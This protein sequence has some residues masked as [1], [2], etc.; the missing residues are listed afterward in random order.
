MSEPTI[1]PFGMWP[2]PVT[3]EMVTGGTV[4][5][6]E[7][8][9][10]G[11]DLYWTELRP[12]ERGRRA[13]VRR[14][15]AGAI[16]DVLPG[17]A[18]LGTRVHE[19]GG[20]AYAVSGGTI[21]YA[22]RSDD[23]VRLVMPGAEPRVLV[24]VAGCRYAAFA[25]DAEH[26]R[27][28]AVREDHRDRPSTAPLNAL[29]VLPLAGAVDA[30]NDAG[31]V[32]AEGHDFFLEP[33]VAP[34]GSRLAW[35]AYDHPDMPWNATRLYVA[36]IAANGTLANVRC[37]AGEAGGESI[38]EVRWNVDGTLLFTSD[39]TNYWNPYV[40]DGDVVTA[41]APAAVEFGE[42]H[43]VFGRGML[44]PLD[45]Q[46]TLCAFIRDGIERPG[47]IAGGR[48]HELPYGAVDG[49]PLPY[50]G[51]AVFLVTPPDAP[52]AIVLAPNLDASDTIVIRASTA[53]VLEPGD[54]SIGE[55]G[56]VT[57]ADGDVAHYVFYPPRNA[58]YAG[59][60]GALPP[61]IVA[62][63][64]GP[65][66]MHLPGF[67]LGIQWWTSRGFALAH[68]NYRGSSGF[69]RAYRDKLDAAWGVVDV[70]DCVSVARRLAESGHCDPERMAIRGGSSSGMTALLAVAT[71]DVFRAA[72]SLYGVME[73]ESLAAE[74]HKFEARYT[75]RLIGPLPDTRQR[76]RDR[77]PVHN[78][79]TIDVPVI[80]FQG[81]DDHAVP[82]G[83]A[84]AMRDALTARGV[85]VTYVEFEGEGHGFRKAETVRRV[86]E[87][88][89]AFYRDV[90]GLTA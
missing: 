61:L 89:L 5:F 43:W 88:E 11:A 12:A 90:F 17:T 63:H 53:A 28:F 24:S 40:W 33:R 73:L 18:D 8:S 64:G 26:G 34:G 4:A 79:A 21:V 2:S 50:L 52:N 9:V 15:A 75:D 36:D 37:I 48:L 62:S 83:Q 74:T 66:S 80:L 16:A 56:T 87:M 71:S 32:V 39:R 46:R 84:T 55:P 14:T 29:V 7:L 67:Q 20:G 86:L 59:P 30:P 58:H 25:I 41:L 13:L 81:L 19:Y 35:I 78:V 65:T 27:V 38:A 49:A 22:E 45:A 54:I 51:G 72:A 60:D 77:S 3:P 6:S 57:T 31:T 85:P 10:D 44:A 82:P 68:V 76:Y 70:V 1:A 47:I 42:P 69:G 23:S